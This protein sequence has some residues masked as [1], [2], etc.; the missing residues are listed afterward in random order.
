MI[1]DKPVNVSKDQ[2]Q[3]DGADEVTPKTLARSGREVKSPAYT[4][5][6]IS[7]WFVM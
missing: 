3:K 6:F 5:N 4:K 2:I 7:K 1:V